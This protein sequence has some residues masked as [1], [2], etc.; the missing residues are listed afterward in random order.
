MRRGAVARK[1]VHV[2]ACP[3]CHSTQLC[4][5]GCPVAPWFPL[6]P[7]ARS[8]YRDRDRHV[9]YMLWVKR[10]PC[11]MRGVWG[12]CYG[13]VEADHA[14]QRGMSHKAH[15]ST[16][17][18]LCRQHHMAS[19][20]P[21]SWGKAQRAAWLHAAIVYTQACAR[22]ARVEV[23]ED[24]DPDPMAVYPAVDLEV[25]RPALADIASGVAML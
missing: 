12:T 22:A 16:C 2:R 9:P 24:P 25:A 20:F 21:I 14:G 5:P 17:I 8:A 7:P 15:D 18:P 10:Q 11:L 4:E 19:R 1:E 13:P 23:P 6:P 3:E